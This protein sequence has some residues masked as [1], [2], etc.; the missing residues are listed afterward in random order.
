MVWYLYYNNRSFP[1]TSFTHEDFFPG[2]CKII[3]FFY[4]DYLVTK[5]GDI[6]YDIDDG[7]LR[8][9]LC[10]LPNCVR[11]ITPSVTIVQ[12]NSITTALRLRAISP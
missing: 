5:N 12:F 6:I 10:S 2:H 9:Q 7:F 8:K 1:S 4:D 3:E 11:G